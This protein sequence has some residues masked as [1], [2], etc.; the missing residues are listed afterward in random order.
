MPSVKGY[1]YHI[2]QDII[3]VRVRSLSYRCQDV[4]RN[5]EVQ[6]GNGDKSSSIIEHHQ[7]VSAGLDP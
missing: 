1:A 7:K 6:C 3:S 4:T 2:R 5:L